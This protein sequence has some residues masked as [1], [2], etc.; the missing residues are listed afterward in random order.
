[1]CLEIWESIEEALCSK[2]WFELFHSD[3]KMNLKIG[4]VCIFALLEVCGTLGREI[5]H[6]VELEQWVVK[7]P[8]GQ[9]RA[10]R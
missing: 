5:E 6:P 2:P 8:Q 10:K 9:E 4:V 3:E 7:V 1:M